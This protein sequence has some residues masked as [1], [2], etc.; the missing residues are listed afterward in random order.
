MLGKCVS[1]SYLILPFSGKTPFSY[2]LVEIFLLFPTFWWKF[3]LFPTFLTCPTTWRPAWAYWIPGLDFITLHGYEDDDEHGAGWSIYQLLG[4]GNIFNRA[5]FVVRHYGNKHIG[6]IR[7]QLI[8]AAAKTSLAK[9]SHMSQLPLV[10]LSALASQVPAMWWWPSHS[11]WRL[12]NWCHAWPLYLFYCGQAP[13]NVAERVVCCPFLYI[14]TP[15]PLVTWTNS[16]P[17]WWLTIW[18][19]T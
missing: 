13:L 1:K 4:E 12:G 2:F 15:V 8:T 19:L 11:Q 6:P 14:G 9:L 5:M 18:V 16:S 7:F 17:V 3:L 10:E